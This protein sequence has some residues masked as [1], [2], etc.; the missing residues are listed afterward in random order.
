MSDL[1]NIIFVFNITFVSFSQCHQKLHGSLTFILKEW[2]VFNH[3]LKGY[4]MI[5]CP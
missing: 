1:T 2:S 4:L 5:K 3:V